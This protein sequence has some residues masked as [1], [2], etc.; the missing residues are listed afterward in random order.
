MAE[1]KGIGLGRGCVENRGGAGL[2]DFGAIRRCNGKSRGAMGR[3][4]LRKPRWLGRRPPRKL[5]D[6]VENPYPES[7]I[8]P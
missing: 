3:L 1:G 6:V 5:G 7:A 4:Q 2:R 8:C